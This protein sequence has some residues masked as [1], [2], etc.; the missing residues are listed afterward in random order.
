MLASSQEVSGCMGLGRVGG[1]PNRWQAMLK[2]TNGHTDAEI[3]LVC[4]VLRCAIYA[5]A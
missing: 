3:C 2:V 5:V 4:S 1:V